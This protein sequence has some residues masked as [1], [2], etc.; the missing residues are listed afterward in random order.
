MGPLTEGKTL[1][2]EKKRRNV[3][4]KLPPPAPIPKVANAKIG[5]HKIHKVINEKL[6]SQISIG[7]IVLA[8][9]LFGSAGILIVAGLV[10]WG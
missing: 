8:G 9:L 3:R 7:N 2:A 6:H 10:F 1:H 4:P 5:T